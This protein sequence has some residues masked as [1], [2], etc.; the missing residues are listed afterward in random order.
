MLFKRFKEIYRINTDYITYIG[1]VQAIKSYIRKTGLTVE[2]NSSTDLTKTLKIIYS[3]QKGSRLYYEMLTPGKDKPK[4]CEKWE[5]RLN[6]DIDWS[7]TF[8]KMQNIQEIKLKWFQIRLV[9]RILATNIVLMHMGIENDINCSF[10]RRERDYQSHFLEM[11]VRKV[12]LGTVPDY[13]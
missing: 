6:T 9:H 3:Q 8:K 2:S 11:C 5:A 4:C 1:C 7:R 12:F 10:C 13:T